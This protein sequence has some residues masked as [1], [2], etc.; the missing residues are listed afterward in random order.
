MTLYDKFRNSSLEISPLGITCGAPRSRLQHTPAN[1]QIIAWSTTQSNLHFCQIPELGDLIF[2]VDPSAPPGESIRPVAEDLRSFIGLIC[3]C[4]NTDLLVNAH[5][6]SRFYF[7]HKRSR[8]ELSTKA[9]RVRTALLNTY[10]PQP[11]SDPH[12]YILKLQS[13]FD[14]SKIPLHP[15]FTKSNSLRPGAFQWNV[16]FDADF[17]DISSEQTE[18]KK[19]PVNKQSQSNGW[20][21]PGIYLCDKGLVV[22][23]Y[24]KVSAET[25]RTYL[26][27]WANKPD[28]LLSAEEKIRKSNE[29][30]L[31]F[32][33]KS[34][35]IINNKSVASR[36]SYEAI[37]NP[38]TDNPWNVRK[39]LEYYGLDKNDGYLFRRDCFPYKRHQNTIR[40]VELVLSPE[41]I[42]VP[43]D[44][45]FAPDAGKNV[46]FIH[47]QTNIQHILT[48]TSQTSEALDPN[49]L[50][51]YPCFYWSLLYTLT[52]PIHSD[53]FRVVDSSPGDHWE[54][55]IDG[56]AALC[57]PRKLPAN[58]HCAISPL[59]YEPVQ[60]I[61]WQMIFKQK[62]CQDIQM[63]L[64]P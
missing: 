8:Q 25:I 62:P 35:L 48:V 38:Y 63:Q 43:G 1:A 41:L 61:R 44:R 14:Y 11:I 60:E 24:K 27:N 12:S 32:P 46:T 26:T 52:P 29:Y 55:D 19:L 7:E 2:A 58:V 18:I 13:S 10:R 36:N 5:Q 54:G 30:P 34:Q 51:N 37:W 9:I 22:D 40:T 16:S 57:S 31:T 28:H 56:A 21:V 15:S 20:Y 64:I 3:Y 47:P 42:S 23:S 39:T 45:F 50:S 49:F 33:A 4:G 17:Y 59:R 6:W 53:L